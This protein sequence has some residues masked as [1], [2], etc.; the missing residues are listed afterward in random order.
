MTTTQLFPAGVRATLETIAQTVSFHYD[1][2]ATLETCSA[3]GD[4]WAAFCIPVDGTPEAMLT[5]Q[6]TGDALTPWAMLGRDGRLVAH[7][8]GTVTGFMHVFES[9]VDH[10]VT[11]SQDPYTAFMAD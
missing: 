5:I 10:A 4:E 11:E 8:D 3:D 7:W 1:T 2:D 9:V 6:T